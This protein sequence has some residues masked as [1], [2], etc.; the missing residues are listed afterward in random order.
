MLAVPDVRL[1]WMPISSKDSIELPRTMKSCVLPVGSKFIAPEKPR[2]LLLVTRTPPPE[3]QMMPKAEAPPKNVD[4][5]TV[6][7]PW[8]A[9][10]VFAHS[11]QTLPGSQHT[12]AS[13]VARSVL[14]DSM[15]FHT[16]RKP[17][18]SMRVFCVPEYPL[19]T[20]GAWSLIADPATATV[21]TMAKSLNATGSLVLTAKP[22]CVVLVSRTHD[23]LVPIAS[24]RPDPSPYQT[25]GL[26]T[27]MAASI[28]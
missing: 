14:T 15:P 2:N 12:M 3:R 26:V 13:M 22:S 23:P 27:V 28:E 7:S 4:R 6:K 17:M 16:P 24:K 25:I 5:V 1:T 9:F 20:P 8:S 19:M 11:I 10:W 18:F 21:E